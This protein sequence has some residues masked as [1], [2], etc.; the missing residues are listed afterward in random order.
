[1]PLLLILLLLLV[2][3]P[4]V[5]IAAFIHVG[6]RIGT[7]PTILLTLFTA[8]L[9]VW[10]VRLQG[11][12]ALADFHRAMRE[13]REPFTTMLAGGLLLL[14]GLLLLIPGFVT[15]AIGFMLLI[16]PL[17]RWLARR[18]CAVLFRP[19]PPGAGGT[20]VIEAEVVEIRSETERRDLPPRSRH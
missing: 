17:R 10:L 9:G 13:G 14:A 2:A 7:L 19:P 18:L 15:D 6:G 1:M 3:V 20:R 4:A 5:E 12:M 11:V 16:P 8:A